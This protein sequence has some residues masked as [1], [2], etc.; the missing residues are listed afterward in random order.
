MKITRSDSEK[1]V[2]VDF[3]YVVG[4]ILFFGASI[5][6]VQL[7]IVLAHGEI[8]AKEIIGPFL[9]FSLFFFGGALLTK[10]SVFEF[11]LAR[12]QLIWSRIGIFTRKGGT[13]PFGMITEAVVQTT[14][15]GRNSSLC[16]R[17]ALTTRQGDIPLSENYSGGQKNAY[18]TLRTAINR[19]LGFAQSPDEQ[20]DDSDLR[21]LVANGKIIDA[22]QL[23]R[24]RR[25]CSLTEAKKIVD[26]LGK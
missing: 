19:T 3:P 12:R 13:V 7:F 25:Q 15:N 17:V 21:A 16:Y 22:I 1:L 11:D 24:M 2:V 6:A 10:R 9:A 14:T 4:G 23:V 20:R 26:D 8:S 5:M 18:E